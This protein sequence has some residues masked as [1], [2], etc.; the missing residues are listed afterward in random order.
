MLMW[1][2]IQMVQIVKPIV[3]LIVILIVI[4]TLTRHI[5]IEDTA[6]INDYDVA[7]MMLILLVCWNIRRLLLKGFAQTFEQMN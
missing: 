5:K 6:E 3:L 4:Q 1:M 7:R 2:V